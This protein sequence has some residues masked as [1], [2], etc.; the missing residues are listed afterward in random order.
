MRR[1]KP[2]C[3]SLP[4]AAFC[5][6]HFSV[7]FRLHGKKSNKTYVTLI[8]PTL[9]VCGKRLLQ[10]GFFNERKVQGNFLQVSQ[11]NKGAAPPLLRRTTNIVPKFA[12]SPR[13]VRQLRFTFL[14]VLSLCFVGVAV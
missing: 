3:P 7:T 8:I 10:D 4:A 5:S 6:I 1:I 2:S 11:G 14:H 13:V 12:C 9:A